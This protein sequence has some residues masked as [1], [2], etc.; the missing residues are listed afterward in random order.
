M[1][2]F[3][4]WV[5]KTLVHDLK[6]IIPKYFGQNLEALVI[7]GAGISFP[8]P[9][10]LPTVNKFITSFI[11]LLDI[12]QAIK[13]PLE[14]LF[15]INTN[16][17]FVKQFGKV[18]FEELMEVLQETVDPDLSILQLLGQTNSP[19]HYHEALAKCSKRGLKIATTNFDCL[20]EKAV[21]KKGNTPLIISQDEEFDNI[22]TETDQIP[23]PDIYKL[24]GSL[25]IYVRLQSTW[26]DSCS[27]IAATLRKVS[28]RSP[29]VGLINSRMKIL[30]KLIESHNVL[31]IGYSGCD[32]YDILPTLAHSLPNKTIFWVRH[33]ED[34]PIK[35]YSLEP[36][37]LFHN[38]VKQLISETQGLNVNNQDIFS[39]LQALYPFSLLEL[40]PYEKILLSRSIM[41][42]QSDS[43]FLVEGNTNE[44][45]DLLSLS[46]NVQVEKNFAFPDKANKKDYYDRWLSEHIPKDKAVQYLI[47]GMLFELGGDFSLAVSVYKNACMFG[48]SNNKY[49]CIAYTKASKLLSKLRDQMAQS[50]A[51]KALKIAESENE[52]NMIIDAKFA[53]AESL[54]VFNK[55]K[56]AQ[57][58]I[59]DAYNEATKNGKIALQLKCKHCFYN[60]LGRAIKQKPSQKEVDEL[61]DIFKYYI[62]E[63][64]LVEAAEA[65][66]DL[67]STMYFRNDF[68]SSLFWTLQS[69]KLRLLES[70]YWGIGTSL[71]NLAACLKELGLYELSLEIGI[72]A[73]NAF[74]I[75]K[76]RPDMSCCI[77]NLGEV[78]R[79]KGIF[80]MAFCCYRMAIRNYSTETGALLDCQRKLSIIASILSLQEKRHILELLS[81]PELT[82]GPLEAIDHTL[83]VIGNWIKGL[84]KK[85]IGLDFPNL[86]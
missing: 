21:I 45:I 9:S 57:T 64:C 40:K 84:H 30:K 65:A 22:I 80:K 52:L 4:E 53:L 77:H 63:G 70:N 28:L 55:E 3:S 69:T 8:P 12:P 5:R 33:L 15:N 20:I 38:R 43:L 34:E 68:E 86:Q 41:K 75:N 25:E 10:N 46:Y 2:N 50:A 11:S 37:K 71:G 48:F 24:H 74:E 56:E 62:Y 51:A 82:V 79:A 49:A 18:R 31:I 47:V 19:N 26:Q 76:M 29:I 83:P 39:L 61:K 27:T 14:N 32:D 78:Y 73:I 59:K 7:A 6:T 36:T 54:Y 60:A 67:S 85:L 23:E 16:Q 42:G 13:T 72:N 35:L 66:V 81:H 44:I 1:E 58:I 17:P